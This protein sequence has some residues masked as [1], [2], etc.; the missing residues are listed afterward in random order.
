MMKNETTKQQ[1]NKGVRAENR[2]RIGEGSGRGGGSGVD[3]RK[4]KS[5]VKLYTASE[6]NAK[7][8]KTL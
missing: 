6:R 3:D 8:K 5:I 2:K 4:L 1:A 7:G